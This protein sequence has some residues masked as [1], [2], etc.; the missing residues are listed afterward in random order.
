MREALD[1]VAH[2]FFRHPGRL[3]ATAE[4]ALQPEPIRPQSGEAVADC[5]ESQNA[6]LTCEH[7]QW[8]LPKLKPDDE[9]A[10]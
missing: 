8:T 7:A 5:V 3:R 4:V 6:S 10:S 9:V 2:D 1:N